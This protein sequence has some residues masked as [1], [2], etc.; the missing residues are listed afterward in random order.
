MTAAAFV[1]MVAGSVL[2]DLQDGLQAH[3]TFD[4]GSGN[5]AYDSAGSN[6][7]ALLGPV[8]TSGLIEY[9]LDFDGTNDYVSV[10]ASPSLDFSRS[11][12]ISAW[13]KPVENPAQAMVWFGYHGGAPFGSNTK[14]CIVL[15]IYPNGRIRFGLYNDDLNT[16]A[17][18]VTFGQW[19][20]IVVSYD[21]ATDASAIYVNGQLKAFGDNGPY[22]G[23]Q[24][25]A[26]IGKWN[27][28]FQSQEHFNGAMDEFSVYDR[29]LSA[30]EVEFL[31]TDASANLLGIDIVG[32]G[33]VAEDFPTSFQA[34][35]HYDNGTVKD[36]TNEAQWF[37][38]PNDIAAVSGGVLVTEKVDYP[39]DVTLTATFGP[40]QNVQYAQKDVS[41]LAICPSGYALD[42][43]GVDDYVD[44]GNSE[45]LDSAALTWSLWIKRNEMTFSD[46]RA[47]ISNTG[48]NSGVEEAA[49]TYALQ[50]DT[51]GAY[52]DKIQF[53]R[54]GL[55]VNQCP[56][57]ETAI[58]DQN[59]HHV[60]VTRDVNGDVTIYIDGRADA[61][62][63]L[64]ERTSYD[65]TYLG[66]GHMSYSNFNGLIDE[67]A[68]YNRSLSP[69]EIQWLMH[70]RPDTNDQSLVGCWGF[71][72]GQGQ[73]ALD[74]SMYGNDGILGLTPDVDGS[75]PVWT[76][77]IAPVGIC[78]P[79][80]I[81]KRNI[82]SI[83]NAKL[84]ILEQLYDAMVK[85]AALNEYMD[86]VFNGQGLDNANKSDIVR[87]QQKITE[88]IH[89]EQKAADFVDKSLD[90]LEEA[91]GNLGI[92]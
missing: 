9:G 3:W 71:D 88:A 5:T 55:P 82:V 29:A 21:Y 26:T 16:G 11:Y 6:D 45:S 28:D 48:P 74:S 61:T 31:Y 75:D 44:L 17:G 24:R 10:P 20:H 54:H 83:E 90:K 65:Q 72:Q 7:A 69:E 35:A 15:R 22:L 39:I 1:L 47:L 32:P 89:N 8:W 13:L 49:G 66:A 84:S 78:T 30:E 2:A 81:V 33:Q 77:S 73:I 37:V 86:V 51:G 70:T 79:R 41:I 34:L 12:T 92:E 68:I 59:W 46:E 62:G 19:N 38:E 42:F 52:Q 40:D 4:E 18:L 43:D 25:T 50:I 27:V 60:A 56:L 87:S 67:V 14:R 64:P 36:V 91:I 63:Y 80:G 23:G 58:T 57:S 85:E 76:D 53:V